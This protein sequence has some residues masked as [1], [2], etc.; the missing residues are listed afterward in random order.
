VSEV[1][2]V[3]AG[4]VERPTGTDQVAEV[5]RAAAA[6]GRSVVPRGA[7]TK[8]TWGR[9]PRSADVL[10]DL[11]GLTGVV[12]HAAGDLIVTARAGTTLA[13]LQREVAAAGQRLALDTTVRGATLGGS[14]AANTSGPRRLFAGTL[15]DLLIGVTLVRAD[16]VVAR[17]GGKVVKNVAG[18]DLGKLL[19]GS[20]GTLAVVTEATFRLHPLPA[21]SRW[22]TA[23]APTAQDAGRL[24]QA[25][26]HSQVVPAALDV[27][28]T[29]S[30]EWAVTVLLE[31]R[32]D[33][34]S[35][36]AD[37]VAALLPGATAAETAP[38]GWG[39][40]PWDAEAVGDDRATALKLTFRL[41]GLPDVL[42]AAGGLGLRGSAGVG[43]AYA[44]V[45]PTTEPAAVAA[46][47]ARV[48]E[49]C[50][51]HGGSAVVLDAPAA[52]KAAVD[53]WGPV[54]GLELMRRVKDEFDP[55]HRLA[56]GRFVGG[57]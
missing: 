10:L 31:G 34:V 8:L 24:T 18:Y 29:T 41:S 21:E 27:A 54:G 28:E 39:D 46:T 49:V 48:R 25:V 6:D 45:P 19:V 55:E 14:L 23:T 2:G 32:P 57:I 12:E 5:L 4:R 26:L 15:R 20:F 44:A 33:G 3:P 53:V 35:G 22:I 43:V 16:G 7:G 56:P 9:P 40:Y 1:D 42:A 37:A 11:S 50:T 51:A 47:L 38:H 13:D 17:S 30:G 52:V 36:R